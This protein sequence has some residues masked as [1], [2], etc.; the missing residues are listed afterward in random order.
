MNLQSKRNYGNLLSRIKSALNPQDELTVCGEVQSGSHIYPLVKIVLGRGKSKR[1][2]IS[3]GIHGDEPAGVETICSFLEQKEFLEFTSGWELTLLPCINPTGY[4]LKTRENHES[5]DLNRLFK[6]EV[7]CPE[8]VYVKNIFERPYDLDLELH[9]DV[10][11]SGYYLYQ[12]DRTREPG[13]LGREILD[14]VEKVMKLNSA[15]EIEG[16]AAERGLISRLSEPDEMEWW[17]MAVYA[18]FRGCRHCFTL[19]TSPEFSMEI[20]VEAHLTALRTALKR[21]PD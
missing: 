7:S 15:D 17:P 20:R 9:E 16:M 6:T 8:M 5:R 10:D 13:T 21:L 18:H 3:A 12:K 1:A 11:T 4:E 2:L 19:E 14:A